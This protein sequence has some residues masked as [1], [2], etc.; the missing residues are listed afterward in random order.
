MAGAALDFLNSEHGLRGSLL[1]ADTSSATP[2]L[3]LP[4]CTERTY[5][6]HFPN[7]ALFISLL[8]T[9]PSVV[10]SV[11]PQTGKQQLLHSLQILIKSQTCPTHGTC[12]STLTNLTLSR[13]LSERT[14][15]YPLPPPPA[16]IYFLN[17]PLEEVLSFKPLGL[18]VCHDLSWESHIPKLASKASR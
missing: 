8:M 9:P 5:K 15:W 3:A 7:E 12:L 18:T 14:I 16:P 1:N 13:C 11:I 2:L 4:G 10:P 6:L 17:N